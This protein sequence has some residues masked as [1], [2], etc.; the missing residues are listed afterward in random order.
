MAF[1]RPNMCTT[2]CNNANRS[3]LFKHPLLKKWYFL[4]LV[5]SVHVVTITS[6]LSYSN[7]SFLPK[8]HFQDL[9]CALHVVTMGK[10]VKCPLL[11]KWHFL[12]LVC[13]IHV[14][15]VITGLSYSN[16]SLLK[17]WH[18]MNLKCSVP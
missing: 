15:T 12:D 4:D 8:W 14:V 2:C 11:K 9:I 18:F 10:E 5:C 7:R 13:S 3:L 16:G 1:S 6:G 17:K